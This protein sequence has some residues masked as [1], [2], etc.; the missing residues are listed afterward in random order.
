MSIKTTHKVMKQPVITVY[1][2]VIDG[3]V[4]VIVAEPMTAERF[5]ADIDPSHIVE[6]FKPLSDSLGHL[7]VV[8]QNSP[9]LQRILDNDAKTTN[10]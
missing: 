10:F 6:H 1:T 8:V 3:K 9:T 7:D 2:A 4:T 5:K